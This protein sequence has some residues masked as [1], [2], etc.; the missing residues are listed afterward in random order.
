MMMIPPT[1]APTDTATFHF[2]DDDDDDDS[3]KIKILKTKR[4]TYFQSQDHMTFFLGWSLCLKDN[5]QHTW[6]HIDIFHQDKRYNGF[7]YHCTLY[8]N[9][10]RWSYML[11]PLPCCLDQL[12]VHSLCN[13]SD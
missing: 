13:N 8:M 11:G 4:R 2:E 3:I 5:H 6:F 12:H 7:L 1:G 9:Y 10:H